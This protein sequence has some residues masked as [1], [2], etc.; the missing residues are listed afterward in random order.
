MSVSDERGLD[1]PDNAYSSAGINPAL[2]YRIAGNRGTI[3]Y[4]S[5]AA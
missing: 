3:A 2:D 5:F 4:R 1:T